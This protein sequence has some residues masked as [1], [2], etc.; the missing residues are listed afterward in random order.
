MVAV[1]VQVEAAAELEARVFGAE[2]EVE[3]AAVLESNVMAAVAAVADAA[4]AQPVADGEQLQRDNSSRW[5]DA[6]LHAGYLT[7]FASYAVEEKP[8]GFA[9]NPF[10]T[11][12]LRV[13]HGSRHWQASCSSA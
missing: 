3:T 10:C 12:D 9:V 4:A 7:S 2:V 11:R 8:A 6:A 5:R 1:A 13:F